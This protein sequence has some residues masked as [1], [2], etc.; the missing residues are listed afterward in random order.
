MWQVAQSL[1]F[2]C[3]RFASLWPAPVAKLT[4]VW[5]PPQAAREGCVIHVVPRGGGAVCLFCRV[6]AGVAILDE[7]RDR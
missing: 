2:A 1:S 5:Q 7:L 4:L 3:G 6:V